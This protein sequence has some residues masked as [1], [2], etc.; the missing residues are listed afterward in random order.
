MKKEFLTVIEAASVIRTNPAYLY[1]LI[2]AG[3]IPVSKID[4]IIRIRRS[5]I[6]FGNLFSIPTSALLNELKRR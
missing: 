3:E 4:G 5:D 1:E 2:H 6:C